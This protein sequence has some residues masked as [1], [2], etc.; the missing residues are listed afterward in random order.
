VGFRRAR[1]GVRAFLELPLGGAGRVG[2]FGFPSHL[3]WAWWWRGRDSFWNARLTNKILCRPSIILSLDFSPSQIL[4]HEIR[5]GKAAWKVWSNQIRC[6]FFSE[7]KYI[8]A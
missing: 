2:S 8:G 7:K 3:L 1:N 6:L 4:C 5:A